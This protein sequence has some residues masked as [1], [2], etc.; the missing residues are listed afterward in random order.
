[1]SSDRDDNPSPKHV[2]FAA[3]ALLDILICLFVA[4]VLFGPAAF[5]DFNSAPQAVYAA[6]TFS[7]VASVC[8]LMLRAK[9]TSTGRVLLATV[10]VAALIGAVLPFVIALS[11]AQ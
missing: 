9:L 10:A 7:T 11:R 4:A 5:G 1:M 3:I 8:L 6:L 2:G